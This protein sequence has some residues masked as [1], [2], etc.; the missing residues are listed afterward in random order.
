MKQ[1]SFK[2]QRQTSREHGFA[3]LGGV[4]L[5]LLVIAMVSLGLDAAN[6]YRAKLRV[7]RAVDATA[8]RGAQLLLTHTSSSDIPAIIAALQTLYQDNLRQSKVSGS[9]AQIQISSSMKDV[10]IHG[11]VTVPTLL[12]S[13]TPWFSEKLTTVSAVAES[14]TAS[15]AISIVLDTTNSMNCPA[16]GCG[17]SGLSCNY[18]SGSTCTSWELVDEPHYCLSFPSSSTCTSRGESNLYY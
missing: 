7:Q 11:S 17:Y 14:E 6:V 1:R 18:Y 5:I 15:A 12:I 16:A 10:S 9:N 4:M 13:V 2:T 3:L 8:I